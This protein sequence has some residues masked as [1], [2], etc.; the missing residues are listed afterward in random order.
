MLS[1]GLSK[2]KLY[3]IDD[4]LFAPFICI[5]LRYLSGRH[6]SI[7][8]LHLKA[9]HNSIINQPSAMNAV[10]FCNN[11]ALANL[12]MRFEAFAD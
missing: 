3:Y 5:H 2:K 11:G 6:I 8:Q 7:V 1:T 12:D 10:L 9:C 4:K